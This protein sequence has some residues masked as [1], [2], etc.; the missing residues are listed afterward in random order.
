M[1]NEHHRSPRTGQEHDFY[2]IDS[3]DWV[4]VIPLTAD[5]K[6]S[7]VKQYRFGTKEFSL[8]TPGGMID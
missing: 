7:P 6:V 8:K 2:L 5:G 3:P 4:S 1:K